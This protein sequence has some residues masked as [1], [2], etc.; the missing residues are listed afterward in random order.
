MKTRFVAIASMMGIALGLGTF[1][2]AADSPA[3]ASQG[4]FYGKIYADWYYDL[5]DTSPAK[6][7]ITEKSQFELSRVYLG[8]NYKIDDRFTVDGLL[9]VGRVDP[10]T[11]ASATFDTTKKT[12]GLSLSKDDRYFAYLKTAY[13]AWKNILPYTTL[14]MGQI[15][16][17]AFN[18]QEG[19]WGHR[20]VYNTLMDKEGWETSADLGVSAVVAPMDMLKITAGVFNGEGYKA[21]QDVNGNYRI[22]GA[23][24]VNPIKGLTLYLFGDWM[25]TGTT[26]DTAQST[27][28]AFA[29]YNIMD[30][31]KIGVEYDA[32]MQQKGVK[33]HDVSGLSIFGMYN[34]IKEL[35]VFARF[36]MMSSKNDPSTGKG[37][38][39]AQDGQTIIGGLQYA[40]V[41]KVKIA[42]NYQ[43]S[44]LK[45]TGA[46]ASDRVYLNGEFDY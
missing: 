33:D 35:E 28:A 40:P 29:G 7:F 23:A 8:Y 6:K 2:S 3:P 11:A 36:D 18:V 4:K 42:A 9:D 24:Q 34:I 39:T 10:A 46:I 30:M 44:L 19:F 5:G 13:L 41:S 38:N 31:G 17:Y 43:H 25:P 16:Y 1:V 27:I 22:A 26:T 15:G 45:A 12:V 32:Q 21:S 37:W 14:S 20:Y